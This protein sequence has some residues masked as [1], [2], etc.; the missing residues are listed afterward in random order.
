MLMGFAILGA[1]ELVRA[2]FAERDV[3]EIE[4]MLPNEAFEGG[5]HIL[6]IAEFMCFR[7]G[8]CH[9]GGEFRVSLRGF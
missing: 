3:F 8:V 1:D 6:G 7:D 9:E 5:S 4:E 2:T